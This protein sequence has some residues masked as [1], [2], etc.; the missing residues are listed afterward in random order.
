[1]FIK[2]CFNMYRNKKR[3][4]RNIWREYVELFAAVRDQQDKHKFATFGP[5][6]PKKVSRLPFWYNWK[7]KVCLQTE[8][9]KASVCFQT[10]HLNVDTPFV[11]YLPRGI[12]ADIRCRIGV[13]Y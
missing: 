5:G 8:R 7:C 12:V 2:Q 1:M 9:S 11:V 6:C 4:R 13:T 3:N 10:V